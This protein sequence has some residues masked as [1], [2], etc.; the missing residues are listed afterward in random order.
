MNRSV[1]AVVGPTA[2]GK[3]ALALA[4]AERFGGE[5]V[6][7]DSMQ[8]YRG[9][10]IGTAKPTDAERARVPHHLIDILD[11]D[12]PCSAA[13]YGD[14]AA[15]VAETILSRSRLPIFCGGTGLYLAAALSGR[16]DA[17]PPSDPALRAELLAR[18]ESEEGRRELYAE[19]AAV[20]PASAKATHPNNLRRVVRALEIY[21]LTGKAKSA[22]DLESKRKAARFDCL[23]LGLDFSDRADLYA[24]IDRRVDLMMEAGLFSEA[25]ALWEKGYLAPGTTAGQAIGYRQF[26]PCFAGDA[27]PEEAAEEIKLATRRYAKRQLTWFRAQPG[28]VWL[29]GGANDLFARA[30]TTVAAWLSDQ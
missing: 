5:I 24:R 26:L 27:T 29:D 10:D 12:E 9:M 20:D 23:T 30:E 14:E 4:L 21:R 8:V 16:H 28:I 13:D 11:P 2:S 22:I 25:K 6:S 3:S 7:C 17:A 1:L 15:R 19:L 18:G